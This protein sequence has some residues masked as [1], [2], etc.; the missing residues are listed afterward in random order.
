MSQGVPVPGTRVGWGFDAHPLDGDPPLILGGVTVSENIG[1]T[2]TSDGDVLAH[3]VTDA[4]LGAAVMGDIGEVFPSDDP[5]MKDANSLFL[6]RQAATMVTAAGL[7][8][9]HVDA[10]VVI[11]QIRV[12]P[13]REPIRSGLAEALGISTEL[14]S[15]KATTTDGLGFIGRGEGLA[16]VAVITLGPLA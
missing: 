8:V 1:V 2:A 9:W 6:L 11:Q 7:A 12:S 13:F 4:L 16:A 10:T 3:A 15:V 5:M 14:V